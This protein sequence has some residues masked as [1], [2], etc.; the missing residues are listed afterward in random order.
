V[1]G[2]NQRSL[3]LAPVEK[4]A[5]IAESVAAE[6]DFER[7]AA[8][9]VVSLTFRQRGQVVQAERIERAMFRMPRLRTP[10]SS[11]QGNGR[12]QFAAM[13]NARH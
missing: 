9:K 4:D 6:I 7:D 5:F 11:R 13:R 3:E 10:T 8:D 12:H 2:T 1:Q